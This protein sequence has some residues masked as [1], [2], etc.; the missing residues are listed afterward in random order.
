MKLRLSILA[1]TLMALTAIAGGG[2]AYYNGLQA[3]VL[4]DAEL[5]MAA[6]A[7]AIASRM[8]TVVTENLK[9][10]RALTGL[11]AL[12]DALS[13][14]D[15]EQIRAADRLLAR[16][17]QA[18]EVSVCYL[19]RAD[20]LTVA[21]SNAGLPGTFVGHN[22][23]FR[24]YF[25][26]AMQG[27]A[28]VHLALG[29]TSGV[30]GIYASHPVLSDAPGANPLG[31]A[32]IKSDID[33]LEE[34]IGRTFPGDWVLTDPEG[35]IFA[36]NRPAW[37]LGELWP[38]IAA[39]GEAPPGRNPTNEKA[40][41]W[42]GMQRT[43]AGRAKDLSGREYLVHEAVV[44]GFP[45]WRVY[46]LNDRQKALALLETPSLKGRRAVL[47]VMCLLF[48]ALTGALYVVAREDMRQRHRTRAA[49]HHHS[50]CMEA[51]HETTLGLVG[52]M[53]LDELIE[54]VLHRA[55]ALAGTPNGFL[56]LWD[57]QGQELELRVGLG[58]Y[59][60]AV[61]ARLRPG[62][63]LAGRI[64]ATGKPLN[65]SDYAGWEGRLAER[66]YDALHAVMGIPLKSGDQVIGVMGLGHF[67]PEKAFGAEEQDTLRRLAE[68]AVI[69]IDNALLYRR[70][71]QELNELERTQTALRQANEELRRL[72]VID[73][74]TQVAN[75]RMFDEHLDAEWRRM[76]REQKPL[77]LLLCDVDHFKAFNDTNGHLA[78]D[79]CLRAIARTI[80][81][82]VR[83]PGDLVARYGGEEFAVILSRTDTA[84]AAQVG[85][86]I[87]RDVARLGITHSASPTAGHV[88]VSLGVVSLT[89]DD[90]SPVERIIQMADQA[91]YMAKDAGRDQVV[92]RH[93]D[94]GGG[95]IS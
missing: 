30:R 12:I 36:G 61:G 57:D 29:V 4:A 67:T 23:A 76:R 94:E 83:R 79:D 15:P 86:Q 37:R 78:G 1:L 74:L 56:Y 85:E 49:L 33:L 64:F 42:I 2:Y 89:P 18:L 34:E 44:P 31:V 95:G 71:Q 90:T 62:Q 88:T 54:T 70:L 13:T 10:V 3:A 81:A 51:L 47:I 28:W 5:R 84:G 32:V 60:E 17:Q 26:K 41:R 48:A 40:G 55:G 77:S 82:C 9:T 8:A 14:A 73:G 58:A 91:L 6:D 21:A 35:R 59:R 69:V 50:A 39:A 24:P 16:F 65:I 38:R 22:Y 53:E 63:G 25:Q 11:P 52:R 72:A 66:H 80:A 19:M 20:G 45:N 68:L 87:R 75:R 27:M 92:T 7:R 46:T 43:Q 93:R